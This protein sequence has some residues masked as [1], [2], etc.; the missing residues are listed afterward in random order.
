MKKIIALSVGILCADMGLAQS[1]TLTLEQALQRARINSPQLRAARLHTQA[2]QKAIDASGLWLNPLL[3]FEAEGVGGDADGFDDGE[4]SLGILQKFQRGGKRKNEREVALKAVGIAGNLEAEKELVLLAEVRLA[5]I[6]L[7]SQQ[8]IGKVRAEQEELGLAFVEVAKR[9]HKAGGGSE[10]EV[11]QAELA[12]EEIILSQTCCFGDLE[13]ARTRLASLIGISMDELK[14]LSGAYYELET[15]EAASISDS[16]PTLLRI[17]AEID[18]GR[19]EAM[20]AKAQDVADITL[21]A[22][23][24][25]E[26]F[27]DANTFVFGASMPLNFS[28]RGRA[29]EVATLLQVDAMQAGREEARRKLQQ[30]LSVLVALYTGAKLEAEMT[31]DKLM[32]K[33]EQAYVLSRAGYDA[34][35]FSWIEL[36]VTQQHLSQISVRHIEAL[37]DAHFARAE[38]YKFM[39]KGM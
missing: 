38:I 29:T 7:M 28:K 22:G 4:Y 15:I 16:H 19:A 39:T 8:E 34:G 25:Y 27:A 20:Q 17:E 23:Y 13:A 36:I 30:E 6:E 21:G 14:E 9:R 33:A 2:A 35:R 11:V 3:K 10:L 31:R 18:K 32:P 26:A 37:K 24:R 12:L 5:F 1:E